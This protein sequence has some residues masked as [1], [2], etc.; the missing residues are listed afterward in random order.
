VELFSIETG[1][2]KLD[3]GA[4]FGVVPKSMWSKIN[5]ADENNMCSWAMRSLLVLHE[6][7]AILVDSGIGNKQS[8]KF[9][10]HYYLHGDDSIKTSLEQVGVTSPQI[11]D[12]ILTHLHFDHVGGSVSLDL[13]GKPVTTFS[14]AKYHINQGQW[15][16]A[17][18]PNQREKASFLK[19]NILPIND[20]GQLFLYDTQ[21]SGLINADHIINGMQLFVVNG[22]TEQMSL[23]IFPYK[24]KHVAFVSDLIPSA[25]HIPLPYIMSYDMR[26]LETL[27]E[28]EILLEMGLGL[29]MKIENWPPP[30]WDPNQTP[31]KREQQ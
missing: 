18:T 21:R 28:K 5:P 23:P 16:W 1:R 2:F 31:V 12:H 11:T 22:H 8:P 6:N 7:Q 24:D 20:S 15:D 25:G 10:S 9:F 17:V 26:P 30:G 19:D 13:E 3:G 27:V 14:N 29:G 4:M